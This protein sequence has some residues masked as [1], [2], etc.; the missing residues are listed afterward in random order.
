MSYLKV[1]NPETVNVRTVYKGQEYTLPAGETK[2]Y[3]A[4]AVAFMLGVYGFLTV[5]ADEP[6]KIVVEKTVEPKVEEK[7][8]DLKPKKLK[9]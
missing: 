2:S 8:K 9:E 5:V 4:D 7:V 1:K 3:P 6:A